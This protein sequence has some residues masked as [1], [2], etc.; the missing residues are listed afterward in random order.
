[1]SFLVDEYQVTT[2]FV[3]TVLINEEI[4]L[5]NSVDKLQSSSFCVF[6]K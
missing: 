3:L 2:G 4:I 6:D 5:A 1:M